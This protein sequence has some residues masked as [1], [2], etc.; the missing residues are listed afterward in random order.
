MILYF[1]SK[2]KR[3]VQIQITMTGFSFM[4]FENSFVYNKTWIRFD[5]W[6]IGFGIDFILR[7]NTIFAKIILNE[8]SIAFYAIF[9]LFILKWLWD[10]EKKM[11]LYTC[12]RVRLLCKFQWNSME[13]GQWHVHWSF[14]PVIPPVFRWPHLHNEIC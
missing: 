2:W 8:M 13:N 10:E 7:T 6:N 14:T 1:S 12:R 9:F 11:K 3:W 4:Y 5:S